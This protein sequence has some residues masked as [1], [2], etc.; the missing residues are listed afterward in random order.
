MGAGRSTP[1]LAGTDWTFAALDMPTYRSD[2]K[3][4]ADHMPLAGSV[5][6]TDDKKNESGIN[7]YLL[8]D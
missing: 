8:H 7:F 6:K 2:S 4:T 5:P 1:P 3:C